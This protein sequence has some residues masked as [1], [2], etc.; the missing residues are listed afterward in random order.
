MDSLDNLVE[1]AEVLEDVIEYVCDKNMISGELAWSAT[2]TI[3]SITGSTHRSMSSSDVYFIV[4]E[5]TEKSRAGRRSW[6]LRSAALADGE[7]PG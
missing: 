6:C 5:L 2:A 3:A 1:I 7:T 4:E